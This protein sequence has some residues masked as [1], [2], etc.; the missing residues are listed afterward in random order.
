MI[1]KRFGVIHNFVDLSEAKIQMDE[2]ALKRDSEIEEK[3]VWYWF[4]RKIQ[5]S[6]KGI[7]ISARSF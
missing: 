6:E 3:T 7:D 2:D 5:H 1:P 4:Y